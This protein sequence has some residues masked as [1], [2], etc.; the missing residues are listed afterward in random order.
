MNAKAEVS[1]FSEDELEPEHITL[2]RALEESRENRDACERMRDDIFSELERFR[3]HLRNELKER[4]RK[5]DLRDGFMVAGLLMVA[6]G[7]AVAFHWAYSLIIMGIVLT[8][9]SVAPLLRQQPAK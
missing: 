2:A 1:K 9:L 3:V 4:K 5:I 6:G 8:I 7:V